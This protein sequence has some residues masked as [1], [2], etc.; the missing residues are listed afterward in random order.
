VFD[1][2]TVADAATFET[3]MERSRGIHHVYVNGAKVWD[4]DGLFT[5]NFPGRVLS[6]G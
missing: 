6:R 4:A 1:P 5:G 3:P 2:A